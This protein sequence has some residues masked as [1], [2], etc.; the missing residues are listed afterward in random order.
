MA[1][2]LDIRGIE[3]SDPGLE[4]SIREALGKVQGNITIEEMES[5][6]HL[7]AS[8]LR[9]QERETAPL[10]IESLEGL[11]TAINLQSLN[12]S[13]YCFQPEQE[14]YQNADL[15]DLFVLE[16]LPNLQELNLAENQL[17]DLFLPEGM[18]NLVT[19]NLSGNKLGSVDLP[20][21]I[22]AQATL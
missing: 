1:G 20:Q 9:R 17:A 19:L 4:S 16:T 8:Y 21:Q 7:D 22:M 14:C 2:T 11:E 10:P 13:G 15:F 18:A 3:I 5:P 6:T 12:L